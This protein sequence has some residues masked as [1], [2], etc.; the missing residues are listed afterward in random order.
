MEFV[1]IIIFYHH[2]SMFWS[3]NPKGRDHLEEQGVG[4]KTILE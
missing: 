4:G 2:E 1:I 3:E